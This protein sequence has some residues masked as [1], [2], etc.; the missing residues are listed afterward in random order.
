MPEAEQR[1]SICRDWRDLGATGNTA[2]VASDRTGAYSSVMPGKTAA[3][4][5]IRQPLLGPALQVLN[6]LLIHH[7]LASKEHRDGRMMSII[8]ASYPERFAF[9]GRGTVQR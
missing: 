5:D 2:T 8:A 7:G 9:R 6:L 1:R 4:P 3:A